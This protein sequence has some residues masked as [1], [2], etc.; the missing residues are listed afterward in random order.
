MLPLRKVVLAGW[1]VW[2]SVL[3]GPS[4]AQSSNQVTVDGS[5]TPDKI[6]DS[7]AYRMFL[8]AASLNPNS[9]IGEKARQQAF[10]SAAGLTAEEIGPAAVVLAQFQQQLMAINQASL[11][12]AD[13]SSRLDALVA[14]TNAALAAALSPGSMTRLT[15]FIQSEK[16]KI[17]FVTTAAMP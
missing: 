2:A 8:A 13:Q 17:R 1:V 14:T 15:K 12:S 6:P 3:V 10:L 7:I 16:R 4:A 9:T 11:S 5:V